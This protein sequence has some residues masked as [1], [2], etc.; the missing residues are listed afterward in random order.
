VAKR[1][2]S[3]RPDSVKEWT[4][5]RRVPL[6]QKGKYPTQCPTR[7]KGECSGEKGREKK[8][9]NCAP[10]RGNQK[11]PHFAKRERQ[12]F[13]HEG[14]EKKKREKSTGSCMGEN[15]GTHAR[16]ARKSE[17]KK[18][19]RLTASG[20]SQKKRAEPNSSGPKKKK[21]KKDW[22]PRKKG[23]NDNE[24]S[25]RWGLDKKRASMLVQGGGGKPANRS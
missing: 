19:K 4:K 25:S 9:F 11:K 16:E 2:P 10:Q 5:K 14:G 18:K 8:T 13:V 15:N 6:R 17:G 12:A 1:N 23:W 24:G 3:P 7:E 21:K 22:L 20:P